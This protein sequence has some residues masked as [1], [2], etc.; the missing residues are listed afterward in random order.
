[1]NEQLI[2]VIIPIYRVEE[3]LDR[4]I[5]SIV[6]QT[7]GKL[8]IILVDDGSPD[9]CPEICDEWASRDERIRVIHRNNGG[10]SAARNDGIRA[11]TG[12]YL[13]FVD[14]D[15]YLELDA[16]ERLL[17]Y[18]VDV[19]IVIGEATII[20]NGKSY[21]S[22]HTNLKENYVY[23]GEEYAQM[24]IRKGEWFSAS[25]YNFYRTEFLKSNGL[26]FMEGVLH[27]DIEYTPRLFLVAKTVKYLH[28]QFY[29]YIRRSDSITGNIGKKNFDDLMKIYES[30][31][32]LNNNISNTKTKRAYDG[33]LS[34]DFISACRIHKVRNI[35]F[36]VGINKKF[37]LKNALDIKEIIKT[38][39]FIIAPNLYIRL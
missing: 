29:N 8:E 16:C 34:K 10:L 20:I 7:Y 21:P 4:C 38:L 35:Q 25:W 24:A 14:S 2:T 33:A 28:F 39:C 32:E 31:Y 23:S 30:W 12:E 37:L 13:M 6:N 3:Y 19:D 36:P 15:D 1:M 22:V 17:N 9:K 26:F 11:S 27:E 5:E 18:A